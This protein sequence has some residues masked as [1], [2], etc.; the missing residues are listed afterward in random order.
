MIKYKYTNNS[1]LQSY[2]FFILGF[3]LIQIFDVIDWELTSF[4][5]KNLFLVIFLTFN[6]VSYRKSYPERWLLNPAVLASILTFFLGYCFTNFIYFIPGSQDERL[7]FRL[8]RSDYL[9]YLNRT[10]DFVLIAA[11]SMWIGYDLKLGVK[12]YHS[13]L[14]FPINFKKY[15]RLKTKPNLPMIYVIIAISI[16]AKLYAIKLGIFGFAMSPEKLTESIGIAHTLLAVGEI[17]TLCLLIISFAYFRNRNNFQYKLTFYIIIISEIFF[18]LLSGMKS[19]VVM[20]FVLVFITYYL[21]NNKLNRSFIIAGVFLIIIAYIIIEPF[22]MIRM[23]EA[24]FQSTPSNIAGMMVDA[25]QLNQSRE[26]VTDT[27]NIFTS[28]ISRNAYLLNATKAIQYADVQ[29]LGPLDPDFREKIYTIP[30]QTFIPRLIWSNKPVEDFGKWFSVRVWGSTSTAAV[31][32]TPIGFL[33][34]AGGWIFIVLGFLIFGVMQ[35]TFWQFHLAGGGQ[36][37]IFLAFLGTVVM[38]D[39]S[40]NGTIVYW[41]RYFP[42]FIFLQAI[43]L[44]KTRREIG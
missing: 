1:K 25:Y 10:M 31:A 21:V 34:F 29:G 15:F 41:L 16:L 42:V 11:I 5:V 22:R 8:L 3:G 43:L 14:R 44:K 27:E 2:F 28:V 38:I 9:F 23:R 7:M 40:F 39:S 18:G 33:Y 30:F 6:I 36:L 37:L 24:G 19:A 17:I 20:P 12:L 4:I 32:I 35:K 13:I 26:I